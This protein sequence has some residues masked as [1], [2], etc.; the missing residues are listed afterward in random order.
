VLAAAK[1]DI[2]YH[3]TFVGSAMV[4]ASLGLCDEFFGSEFQGS[5]PCFFFFFLAVLGFELRA[6]RL[7]GRHSTAL[8]TPPVLPTFLKQ[9]QC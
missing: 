4:N 2:R 6:S 7:L 9:T 1:L 5:H 3:Q 8:N